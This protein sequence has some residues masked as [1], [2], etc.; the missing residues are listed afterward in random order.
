MNRIVIVSVFLLMVTPPVA[1]GQTQ[2]NLKVKDYMTVTE[3]QAAGLGKLTPS[4]L[5]ALDKWFSTI[6][7][8]LVDVGTSAPK[9]ESPKAA[10][11]ID[12]ASLEG[13]TIIADDGQFLGKIT[14]N[15]IDSQSIINDI[16]RHGS[17]ISSTS[18]RNSIGRYG[19]TIS[20]QSPFN[21]ITSTP[22]RIYKKGQFVAYLTTNRIKTPRIDPRALIGWL[23]SQK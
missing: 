12:F 16:G 6:S 7:A 14:T 10:D 4:E 3:F 8:R 19:S 17:E 1:L 21:D 18:I 20:P 5:A 11:V 15:T 22:P 23:Q 9:T 13:A 2:L